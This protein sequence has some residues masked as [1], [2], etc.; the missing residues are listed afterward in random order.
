MLRTA[1]TAILAFAALQVLVLLIVATVEATHSDRVA[2]FVFRA[3]TLLSVTAGASL[4]GNYFGSHTPRR[5]GILSVTAMTVGLTAVQLGVWVTLFLVEAP[6]SAA[7]IDFLLQPGLTP[8]MHSFLLMA[9]VCITFFFCR[10]ALRA[11]RLIS[12]TVIPVF[13]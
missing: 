7:A 4:I 5:P 11:R 2:G 3:L 9:I 1:A 12:E 8:G 6:G 13:D 10:A